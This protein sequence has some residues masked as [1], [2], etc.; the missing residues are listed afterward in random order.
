MKVETLLEHKAFLPYKE[1]ISARSKK[2]LLSV[3]AM[4]EKKD[5]NFHN[6]K[7]LL[8]K[9]IKYNVPP[10]WCTRIQKSKEVFKNDS[11]SLASY[12]NRYGRNKGKELWKSKT[13]Q[14]TVTK[15]KYI[16]KH[17]KAAWKKLC[18]SKASIDEAS[19]I[20]RYGKKEGKK[21]RQEYLTKWRKVVKARGGWNNGLSLESFVERHGEDEGYKKWNKR[22]RNQRKRFSKK[23]FKEK[24]GNKWSKEWDKYCQH[25]ANNSAKANK[26]NSSTYSKKS[27]KLF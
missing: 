12:Q 11:S 8:A 15:E 22:R 26:V 1:E 3:Y 16:A 4:C 20:R 6:L 2:E 27:Q 25:M 21:K 18:N 14:T 5:W 9:M 19:F 7:I 13:K 24:H 17:G 23:W 10:P